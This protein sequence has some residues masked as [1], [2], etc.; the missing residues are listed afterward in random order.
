LFLKWWPFS[1]AADFFT[2]CQRLGVN[3]FSQLWSK[4]G[5]LPKAKKNASEGNRY[6]R[7]FATEPLQQG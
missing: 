5:N 4:F 1:P 3:A 6:M 7:N 2:T